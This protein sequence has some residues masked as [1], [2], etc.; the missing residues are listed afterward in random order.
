MTRPRIVIDTNVLISAA[1]KLS[2]LEAQLLTL[3]AFSG[4]PPFLFPNP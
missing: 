3:V 1:M 4:C 2:G